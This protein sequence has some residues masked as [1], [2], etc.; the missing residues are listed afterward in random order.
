MRILAVRFRNLNSLAGEW[1]IDFSDP[2]YTSDGIFAITGP[3]GAG[4]TTLL[5]AMCLAL[6]RQT[7][8]LGDITATSNEIMTR[9]TGECFA[10]VTFSTQNGNYRAYWSQ[11]RAR[12]HADGKLQPARHEIY[13]ADTGKI[14]DSK[15]GTVDKRIVEIT[16]MDFGRFT[17]SMLLAQGGFA[18]FLRA[19]ADARAPI[20]EKITG[21][22][23]Y[24]AISISVHERRS[25][26]EQQLSMLMAEQ[27]GM[28][29]LAP[30]TEVELRADESALAAQLAIEADKA[31][32]LRGQQQWKQRCLQLE[33]QLGKLTQDLDSWQDQ[34]NAFK[35]QRQRL[36]GAIRA[37]ELSASHTSLMTL[38]SDQQQEQQALALDEDKLPELASLMQKQQGQVKQFE[39]TLEDNNR[40]LEAAQP[41]LKKVHV[42]DSR[43]TDGQLRLQ[44]LQG[45]LEEKLATLHRQ[46]AGVDLASF[47][48]EEQASQHYQ[49]ATKAVAQAQQQLEDIARGN[50]PAQW[51]EQS[52]S[53]NEQISSTNALL[54][55]ISERSQQTQRHEQLAADISQK[56]NEL[57]QSTRTLAQAEEVLAAHKTSLKALQDQRALQ[58]R[59]V[60]LE[61]MR[62]ELEHG[63]SCP[64][65]GALEH[66]YAEH[67]PDT[68]IS[69]VSQQIEALEQQL[70]TSEQARNAAHTRHVQLNTTISTLEAQGRQIDLALQTLAQT[71][72]D[73]CQQLDVDDSAESVALHQQSLQE[74][75]QGISRT[76]QQI[77]D[78][79]ANIKT[80]QHQRDLAKLIQDAVAVRHEIDGQQQ[81]V[82]TLR[83]ERHALLKDTDPD[84]EEA[85]LQTLVHQAQQALSTAQQQLQKNSSQHQQLQQQIHTHLENIKLRAQKLQQAEQAFNK[86]LQQ[87]GFNNEQSFVS[88]QLPESERKT[89]ESEAQA[90]Q[91]KGSELRG[92]LLRNRKELDEELTKALTSVSLDE[93]Q[94]Q[95]QTQD[96]V[97]S[98]LREKIGALRQRLKD[99]DDA[100][101]QQQTLAARIDQQK[102]EVERWRRLHV[103]IGSNDGKKFRNF[104][105]GLTF[106]LMIQHA[107]VQLQKMTERYL[108][109]RDLDQPLDLNVIDNYQAG[110]VRSTK[111]LS[112]GESFIVSLALALGLSRM[113]SQN[114][115]VDSLFLDEGFGTLDEDALDTALETLSSLQ[116]EGKLIGV[117]SH[118]AALK[119]RIATQINV[120]PLAGGRSSITGPGCRAIT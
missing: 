20:L 110:E 53:L 43:L 22:A 21:T 97:V 31:N 105:Q 35:G 37:L 63:E 16:G 58:Q 8:R 73:L 100:R 94:Q 109:Q 48:N 42:L 117:I 12:K 118:V 115:R 39:K 34:D 69:S 120:S 60:N 4:K 57:D 71:I 59:I 102:T 98:T 80:C 91:Q 54:Q 11:H 81:T 64:L 111:N 74:Q 44:T 47:K 101:Q 46:D 116:Q 14:I 23:I 49:S 99:N 61:S 40:Q 78:L 70:G 85:R 26:E 82:D 72:R 9:Q 45:S 79:E 36:A 2:A 113:A 6:Y 86:A 17:Q 52:D 5:D 50:K 66:P 24:S 90:L 41:I 108:L 106:E 7:P 96:A 65:C 119:E 29:L 114:V 30:E 27:E 76:L 89:L 68:D 3:T 1:E 10:E 32:T 104:A 107:N 33:Q 15:F 62:A 51:R 28:R 88:A 56:Q 87:Q 95:C 38:R 25:T 13:D 67:A 77:D 84:T 18:A 55:K 92:A 83:A 103:L 93:L 75:R 19:S 112:G